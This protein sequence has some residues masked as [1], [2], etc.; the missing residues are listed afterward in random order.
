MKHGKEVQ[1]KI[2]ILDEALRLKIVEGKKTTRNNA[3]ACAPSLLVDV[4]ELIRHDARTGIQRVTKSVLNTWTL[5]PPQGFKVTPIYGDGRHYRDASAFFEAPSGNEKGTNKGQIVSA[6]RGD[7]YISL[8]L[9]F[10]VIAKKEILQI[11][12]S[13]GIKLCFM[14][15]DILP[16]TLSTMFDKELTRVFAVWLKTVGG[17]ADKLIC[18]S[19]TVADELKNYLAN[20]K[21]R[22]RDSL[23]IAWNLPGADYHC[24]TLPDSQPEEALQLPDSLGK[25]PSFLMVATL[26]PRKC[27][28]QVLSAFELLWKKGH[29]V[30]LV[31]VGKEGWMVKPLVE[32]IRTHPELGGHLFWFEGVSDATLEAIY[33]AS[34]CLI[35]ASLG[36]GFGLP[37]I[38]AAKHNLPIIARD[39]PIFREVME[40]HAFFFKGNN[41]GDLVEDIGQWLNLFLAG[42]APKSSAISLRSWE[43]SAQGLLEIILRPSSK[44]PNIY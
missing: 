40:D 9:N 14:I 11:W 30:N 12:H 6:R 36:E 44:I 3:A 31:L 35:M 42:K 17:L 21:V 43:E 28:H 10:F 7:I 8:E 20:K 41:A 22:V 37:L 24:L 18:D 19:K 34:T 4:S 25:K 32:K 1:K 23:E 26:E 16:L 2:A 33:C 38:E 13:R 5:N 27:H 39:I 29:D 15:H